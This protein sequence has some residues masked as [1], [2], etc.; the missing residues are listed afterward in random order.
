[1]N[2]ENPMG[3]RYIERW[4]AE[5]V[6]ATVRVLQRMFSRDGSLIPI[7]VRVVVDRRRPDRRRLGD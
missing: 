1:M 7:P 4:W 2:S 5:I 3:H 6:V